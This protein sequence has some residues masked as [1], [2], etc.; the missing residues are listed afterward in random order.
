[1]NAGSSAPPLTVRWAVGVP[2][3]PVPPTVLQRARGATDAG[4]SRGPPGAAAVG[5]AAR[6]R[7]GRGPRS[8][9]SRSLPSGRPARP[10]P[11]CASSRH[12]PTRRTR[13]SGYLLLD[14]PPVEPIPIPDFRTRDARSGPGAERQPPRHDLRLSGA[15]GLVSRPPSRGRG[16]A[17]GVRRQRRR[18]ALM[19]SPRRARSRPP[20]A[21]ISRAADAPPPGRTRSGTS[22]SRPRPSGSW[23]CAT[24]WWATTPTASWTS[25]SSAASRSQIR[26]PRSIFVN[27][28]DTKS[29]QMFTLA[30][31]LVHVWT[32][33]SGLG[34]ESP[35]TGAESDRERW[36]DAVAAELLVPAHAMRGG[37]RPQPDRCR[38]RSGGSPAAS[39]SALWSSSG[40]PTT[41]GRSP[42][43]VPPRL[44]GRARTPASARR[45]GHRWRQLPPHR[46]GPR[47]PDLR[48]GAGRR[49]RSRAGP[50]I[51]TPSACSASR[52]SE[53]FHD[54]GQVVGADGLMAY[55][56]DANVFIEGKNRYYGFDFCPAFWDWLDAANAAN[57]V[58][59]I[60]KVAD[61]LAAIADDL[62]AWA[63][64]RRT[65]LFLPVEP[66][67]LDALRQVDCWAP[68]RGMSPA[69][70]R[71]S[72]RAPT[73]T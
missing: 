72:S 63:A 40:A 64:S 5:A 28:A 24:A 21:S 31:E 26:S 35:L 36:C 68:G 45:A 42:G 55:L 13:R 52:K 29:A 12:S 18:S 71:P 16:A 34:D 49:A 47:E 39:R 58:F 37:L 4:T 66:P 3:S 59:S 46:G 2:H 7:R 73:P 9:G 8:A 25:T 17:A 51:A 19:S 38:R 30:H 65:R 44:R 27:G 56:L 50:C 69:P 15:P 48:P 32:G 1:M 14:A 60:E 41:S 61:E 11:P 53:T 43:D 70:S 62:L 33:E 10:R 54:F 23:S 20:S 67:M 6:P 57:R 22:S